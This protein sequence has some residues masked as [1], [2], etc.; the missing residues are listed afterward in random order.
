MKLLL[1]L[2]AD[3]NAATTAT[4]GSATATTGDT[5][6]HAVA[7]RGYD[8]ILRF[9]ADH[10]ASLSPKNSKGET[11][12]RIASGG[13]ISGQMVQKGTPSTAA[14]LSTLGATQ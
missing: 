11:P 2:G 9:L 1:D 8:I 12:L 6:M 4:G 10:G 13:T 14:L 5:A 3:I 7:Q